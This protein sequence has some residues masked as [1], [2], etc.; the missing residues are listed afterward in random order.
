MYSL[1]RYDETYL[2]DVDQVKAGRALNAISV[3]GVPTCRS[4]LDGTDPS[5]IPANI[6]QPHG[7][8]AAQGAYL[9]GQ[10]NTASR[11][12]LS[13]IQG[14]LSGDLASWASSC[15]G[16]ARALAWRWA[17]TTAAR[18]WP[19]PPTPWPSRTGRRIRTA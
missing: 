10:S 16:P 6:F 17:S 11:N 5:C 12:S 1:V 15:P 3:N 18:R 2:N 14:T 8:T 13:V 7:L 9:F 4:V 19:S